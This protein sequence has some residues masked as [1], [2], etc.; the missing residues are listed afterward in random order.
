MKDFYSLYSFF[1]SGADP[2][3]DGNA[4]L[5]K[6]VLKITTPQQQAKLKEFTDKLGAIQKKIDEKAASLP[7]T[8]PA[9]GQPPQP[10]EEKETVWVDDDFPAGAKMKTATGNLPLNWVT[11]E[12][13]QVA[14]GKRAIKRSEKGLGQDFYQDGAAPLAVPVDARIFFYVYLDPADPPQEIMIQFHNGEWKHRAVWGNP[15]LIAFGTPGT[16][17]S[18]NIGTGIGTDVVELEAL[19]RPA[20][21]A[22]AKARGRTIATPAPLH[23]PAR[24]GDLRSNLVDASLAKTILGWQPTVPLADGIA[25]TAEWFASR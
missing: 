2:V 4:L 19:I 15:D 6:P 5:T 21:A 17:T 8:D 14:K 7:Y 9:T 23:G 22:A 25:L 16:L 18:L 11:A 13:G 20:I 12:N 24:P 1:Q 10:V 3:M